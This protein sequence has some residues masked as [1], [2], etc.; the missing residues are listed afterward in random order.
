[1]LR[2]QSHG[3]TEGLESRQ[4]KRAVTCVLRNLA[5]SGFAF[6]AQGLQ[7]RE[8]VREHLHNNR[9]GNVRHDSECEDRE[10]RQGAAGEHVKQTEDT[11]LLLVKELTQ[12]IGIDAGDRHVCTD[13][14]HD[15]G[16]QQENQT[17]F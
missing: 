4:Q 1:M 8:H 9:C 14:V 6:L 7:T 15:Q 13:A 2:F 3:N 17:A 10:T 16:E 12:G 5:T 11:A